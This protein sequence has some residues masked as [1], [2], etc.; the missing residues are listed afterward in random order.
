MLRISNI[1]SLL[2]IT[3]FLV[4]NLGLREAQRQD[5]RALVDEADGEQLYTFRYRQDATGSADWTQSDLNSLTDV[6]GVEQVAWRGGQTTVSTSSSTT[7][8]PV[9]TASPGYLS[10]LNYSFMAGEDLAP[11]DATRPTTVLSEEIARI[12]FPDEPLD[13]VLG[14]QVEFGDERLTVV[15]IYQ[16][17]GLAYR[18]ARQPLRNPIG[19]LDVNTVYLRAEPGAGPLEPLLTTWLSGRETLAPLEAVSYREMVNPAVPLQ[20]AE[21]TREIAR[22][23]EL[24]TVCAIALATLNI[25]H[26]SL[27]STLA[28][29]R[30]LAITRVLGANR[31]RLAGLELRRSAVSEMVA[32]TV[33][34]LLGALL[35]ARLGGMPSV[36]VL[37]TAAAVVVISLLIGSVPG[38]L[39]A[40]R[41][42]PWS[43][44]RG[45]V[46]AARTPWLR[47]TGALGLVLAVALVV[48]AGTFARSGERA[49]GAVIDGIG[50]DLLRLVPDPSSLAAARSPNPDDLQRLQAALPDLPVILERQERV[51]I[52]GEQYSMLVVEGDYLR[53]SGTRMADGGT[54]DEGVLIG[55][56][57]FPELVDGTTM[58]I[59]FRGGE[60]LTLPVGGVAL[61][62]SV[63]ELESLQLAPNAVVVREGT[64]PSGTVLT[65]NM[66]VRAEPGSPIVDQ[67]LA[68]MNDGRAGAPI[69]AREMAFAFKLRLE[70][71]HQQVL[72]FR[73][74]VLFVFFLA[75]V[76][77]ATMLAMSARNRLKPL[78]LARAFGASKRHGFLTLLARD[79]LQ[80]AALGGVGAVAGLSIAWYLSSR[81]GYEFETPVGWLLGAFGAAVA[82][83]ACIGAVAA[84]W[85]NSHPPLTVLRSQT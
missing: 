72:R 7:R 55:A 74:G 10:F 46:A 68:V 65:R 26:Q 31:L 64:I 40:V 16:G 51:T 24:L 3:A 50:A 54:W 47:V 56:G 44:L 6:L 73:L 59:T 38:M 23:F 1:V 71:L 32:L 14:T 49:V 30:V 69:V 2:C 45:A 33:G 66:Y 77:L 60:T 8:V 63:A 9:S 18:A 83:G 79:T 15:G 85:V 62:P 70:R 80:V 29:R 11:A 34:L 5:W 17:S 36:A 22:L 21:Y 78:A 27:L 61:Q 28:R 37:A 43:V 76:A 4:V 20:R 35:T 25:A 19:R 58:E 42:Y 41:D 82:I 39:T 52:G 81:S 84:S 12:L 48:V 75:T 57:L 67:A 53:V 13:T